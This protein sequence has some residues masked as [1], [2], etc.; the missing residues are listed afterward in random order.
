MIEDNHVRFEI[1]DAAAASN[2][3]V[4]S[5]KLLSLAVVV[6]PRTERNS[7]TR[8]GL[9]C[10]ASKSRDSAG[11]GCGRRAGAGGDRLVCCGSSGLMRQQKIEEIRAQA[12][13]LA[14]TSTAALTF[15]DQ[16][17][18]GGV[19]KRAGGQSG[20]PRPRRSMT[21]TAGCSPAFRA[22]PTRSRRKT[23]ADNR[24]EFRNHRALGD[25]PGT[26]RGHFSRH[27]LHRDLS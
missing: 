4:I 1:N 27:H 19:C 17:S 22:S 12:R 10:G 9:A 15:N 26:A 20:N 6:T 13:I 23:A 14:A 8:I 18:R 16:Q 7:G 3:L 25:R 21:R 24:A 5:S 2:G 11:G